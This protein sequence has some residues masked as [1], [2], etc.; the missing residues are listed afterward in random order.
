MQ[1]DDD[2]GGEMV[3]GG[4]SLG[5]IVVLGGAPRAWARGRVSAALFLRTSLGELVS[6]LSRTLLSSFDFLTCFTP[7]SSFRSF[8]S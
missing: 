4:G 5:G 8:S 1:G 7:F 6:L 3:M 2:G